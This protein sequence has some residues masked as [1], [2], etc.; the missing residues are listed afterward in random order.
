M[1]REPG[2]VLSDYDHEMLPSIRMVVA[3]L[4]VFAVSFFV[5]LHKVS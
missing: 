2:E 1:N 5:M 3:R 4:Q